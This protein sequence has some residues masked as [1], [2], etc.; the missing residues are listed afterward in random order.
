VRA[1]WSSKNKQPRHLLWI[2]RRGEDYERKH[3]LF[4]V[5]GN[6]IKP[7]S[8]VTLFPVVGWVSAQAAD[9]LAAPTLRIGL[10]R[11][12]WEHSSKR[13]CL[14]TIIQATSEKTVML[15]G[16]TIPSMQSHTV[17]LSNV[18]PW[19]SPSRYDDNRLISHEFLCYLR[20]P[21]IITGGKIAHLLTLK[22]SQM[23]P[24]INLRPRPYVV[25]VL[26][27]STYSQ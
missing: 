10:W 9:V 15:L 21:N 12:R 24:K 11:E 4:Q 14:F 27:S 5:M 3:E 6:L 8:S 13:L 2:G 25:V 23:I 20:K 19:S 17:I 26:P 1:V 7:P 16:N 18:T 22:L